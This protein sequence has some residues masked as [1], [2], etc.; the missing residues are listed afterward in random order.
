[1]SQHLLQQKELYHSRSSGVPITKADEF[2]NDIAI[3]GFSLDFPLAS[4][5]DEFWELVVSGRCA[6]REFP[7]D[8]I[9]PDAW[10]D[11]DGSL[12]TLS[13]AKACFLDK[14]IAGFDSSFFS[15]TE[16]EAA[17]MDPQQRCL[18]EITYRALENAGI[19]ISHLS[20]TDASVFTGNFTQDYFSLANKD[21]ERVPKYAGTGFAG[22]ML[23]NRI[24]TFFNLK[25]PSMTIDTACSS[26]LTAL[27]MACQSI[28]RGESSLGIVTGS[29]LVYSVDFNISLSNMGFLSPDGMCH[30]F[31][32][33]ANG[34]G[35]GEGFAALIVK[36]LSSALRDGDTVRAIIRATASNQNGLTSLGMP[37]KDAQRRLI[38]ETYR[39]AGLDMSLTQFVEAH[40]TGTAVGDPIEASAIGEAFGRWR[41]KNEPL[42]IGASKANIGHL[43]GASGVA[44][45]VKTILVLETGVIPPIANL[46]TLN[47]A[48]DAKFLGLEFP[49]DCVA[50]P[51]EGVRRASI[52]SFGFGGANS[53]AILDDAL[54]FFRK[55][56]VQ[57]NHC[58]T[59]S[60]SI[61]LLSRE[62][63]WAPTYPGGNR[64]DE[65][66]QLFVWSAAVERG[67][68]RLRSAY[69]SHLKAIINQTEAKHG[70]LK[71]L[72]STLC[73]KR[74]LFSWRTFAIAS[75]P[76]ELLDTFN[77]LP[78]PVCSSKSPRLGLVFTG[79]G[80][81]WQ[82]MGR[83]LITYPIFRQ[84]L[85]EAHNYLK[86][87]GCSWH[88]Q[89]EFIESLESRCNIH[90]AQFSQPI[91]TIVQVALVDL[92]RS[93]NI[94]P[95]VVLG[96]SSGEIAAAYAANAISCESAW[97]LAYYRGVLSSDLGRMSTVSGA[98]ISTALSHDEALSYIRTAAQDS[99][100]DGLCIACINSPNNVTI[101]GSSPGVQ[102]LKI[103]LDKD[104]I[105]NRVL[106]VP[107]A[108][109][110]PQMEKI[111]SA[112]E[113]RISSLSGGISG[114]QTA[115]MVSSVTGQLVAADELL[116][117]S[118]WS[119]NLVS[120]VK[121]AD[122]LKTCFS[123]PGGRVM[124]KIDLSHRNI[125]HVSGLLEIGP[126]SALKA[127]IRETIKA[128]SGAHPVPYTSVL[129]RQQSAMRTLMEAMGRLHCL[130]YPVNISRVNNVHDTKERHAIL[131][132]LPEYPFDHSK[133]Y[134]K[135]SRISKNMR[136]R[137]HGLNPFLGTPVADWDPLQPRWR[138]FL[139]ASPVSSCAWIRD[140]KVGDANHKLAPL[141]MSD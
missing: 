94:S 78:P 49:R 19:P 88:P 119:G 139:S 30:S 99:E 37:N 66:P 28:R 131:P 14:D 81:Q 61:D 45:V 59:A 54:S 36:P 8:R 16:V 121:F 90:E 130:G 75:T 126:H 79:Q 114:L 106:A 80:A 117:P 51:K 26:S 42:Y 74:S 39:R 44:G 98:M 92:L 105:F 29:N 100:S 101:S 4:S 12:G 132:N 84:S 60:P 72:A 136:L 107:V 15:I 77:A 124:K 46:G 140:H 65:F 129:M 11:S 127:P 24:S 104:D 25:G 91:C 103:L 34:Y 109:H 76:A 141:T 31:D 2:Q 52:N 32:Q 82:G 85:Q 13:S 93:F 137:K 116:R 73:E 10:H 111:A 40:G 69:R 23:S 56:G 41:A 21:P 63:C 3:I 9:N 48:V 55:H 120:P 133:T 18:L 57:G 128:V 125:V 71:A 1:M 115:P 102:R 122:A 5:Q 47:P 134:W 95:S 135:E 62:S 38:E 113:E 50:W 89:E 110:S 108:Y 35:R 96:H 17:A 64:R 58:T 123:A 6:A 53:H 27:D 20:G 97:K 43:E 83:D 22:S 112:Y 87:L 67:I 86:G 7:R 68:E 118:Y 70:Y 138:H 33:R